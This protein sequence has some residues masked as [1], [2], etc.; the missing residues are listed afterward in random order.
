MLDDAEIGEESVVAA[1][2][3]VT[4]RTV[5]PPRILITGN[6]AQKKKELEGP[7]LWWVKESS[8]V[9]KELT[10]QYLGMGIGAEREVLK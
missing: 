4:P 8:N 10:K 2:S 7:A 6:P 9:Y 5:F 1:G 3:I